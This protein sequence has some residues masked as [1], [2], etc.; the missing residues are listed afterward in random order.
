MSTNTR[1]IWPK[2][3]PIKQVKDMRKQYPLLDTPF[4]LSY[5]P[6]RGSSSL[7]KQGVHASQNVLIF[8]S[9]REHVMKYRIWGILSW[10]CLEILCRFCVSLQ[11]SH[12]KIYRKSFSFLWTS[13]CSNN[14]RCPLKSAKSTYGVV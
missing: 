6:I 14:Y 11:T 8:F 10:K 2:R 4:F 5:N 7:Q 13:W 3:S 1:L 12:Y 9:V